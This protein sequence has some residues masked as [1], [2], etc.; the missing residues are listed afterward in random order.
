MDINQ[1][2]TANFSVA[3]LAKMP[4]GTGLAWI[5][6]KEPLVLPE[7]RMPFAIKP[8][9][10]GSDAVNSSSSSSNVQAE[11][12]VPD[13]LLPAFAAIDEWALATAFANRDQW[14]GDRASFIQSPRD[15]MP[16]YRPLVKSNG[17]Y[18]GLFSVRLLGWGDAVASV[19]TNDWNGKRLV[20][21]CSWKTCESTTMPRNRTRLYLATDASDR[22]NS[23]KYSETASYSGPFVPA[24]ERK[25]LISP[26]DIPAGS[27][28]KVAFKPQRFYVSPDGKFGITCCAEAIFAKHVGNDDGQRLHDLAESMG[29]ELA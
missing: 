3:P 19:E 22:E 7:L 4:S 24:G 16:F 27:G 14:F 1:V 25:R 2:D 21:S 11:V 20:K 13:D 26:A 9:G 12:A 28:V 10:D 15:L 5:N 18:D 17:N 6:S 23:G 8:H 29:I